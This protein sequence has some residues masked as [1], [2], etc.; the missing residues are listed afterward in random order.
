V[1]YSSSCQCS[2]DGRGKIERERMYVENPQ[3]HKATVCDTRGQ[4]SLAI[5]VVGQN[6][7]PEKCI[8]GKSSSKKTA[9]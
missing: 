9:V 4:C 8:T 2:E 6:H 7:K 1:S 5:P 3:K